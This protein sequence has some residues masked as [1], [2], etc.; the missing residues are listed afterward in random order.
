[1]FL[2]GRKLRRLIAEIPQ[3][4]IGI[5]EGLSFKGRCHS[6]MA[7]MLGTR[8]V[9]E[10]LSHLLVHLSDAYGIRQD[11]GI[12]ISDAFTHAEP[13]NMVGATR[14]W[15]TISLKKMEQRGVLSRDNATITVLRRDMLA[16]MRD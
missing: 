2:E 14:Q 12:L 4:A 7:Q 10:R 13:A 3:L 9:T 5:I 8:S 1:V 6:T 16:D 11:D 15:V